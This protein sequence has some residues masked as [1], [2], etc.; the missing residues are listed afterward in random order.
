M[1]ALKRTG[2]KTEDAS[3]QD[4]GGD[5]RVEAMPCLR[6]SRCPYDVAKARGG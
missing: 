6:V 4:F 1:R 3:R 2:P 5:V